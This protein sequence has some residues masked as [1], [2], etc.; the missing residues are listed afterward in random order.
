MTSYDEI[1]ENDYNLPVST[2]LMSADAR[3]KTDIKKLN[4][5]TEMIVAHEETLDKEIA[6]SIKKI[7][8]TE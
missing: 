2:C 1:T 4:N 3:E 6:A 5:E 8:V 7:E